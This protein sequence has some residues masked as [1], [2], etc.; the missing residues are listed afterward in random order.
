MRREVERAESLRTERSET[1][2]RRCGKVWEKRKARQTALAGGV[3]GN[4]WVVPLPR[5]VYLIL[6]DGAI[7]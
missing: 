4:G 7:R 6:V 3:K 5:T 1:G 2:S